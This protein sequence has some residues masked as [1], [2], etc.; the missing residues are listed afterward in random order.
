MPD[1]SPR[2]VSILHP[3]LDDE[4]VHFRL[5]YVHAAVLTGQ[6]DEVVASLVGLVRPFR[7][8]TGISVETAERI[9]RGSTSLRLCERL[10]M[11][12]TTLL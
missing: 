1:S 3:Q 5:R 7:L 10:R 9:S 12:L 4:G 6:T 2:F 8:S 11:R